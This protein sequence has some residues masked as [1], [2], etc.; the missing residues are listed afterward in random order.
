MY[1]FIALVL[2]LGST[3]LLSQDKTKTSDTKLEYLNYEQYIVEIYSKGEKVL[4][5]QKGLSEPALFIVYTDGHVE[6]SDP[7][8]IDEF[9]KEFWKVIA[10]NSG[11]K[12]K[13]K[14]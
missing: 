1:W 10:Q 4:S 8:K 9:S 3:N 13:E 12:C 11:Y 5:L 14:P 2:L 7:S 6:V